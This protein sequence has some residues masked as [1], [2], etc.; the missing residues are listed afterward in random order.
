MQT[1]I[2][3]KRCQSFL[4]NAYYA[5]LAEVQLDLRN[6]PEQSPISKSVRLSVSR[7]MWLIPHQQTARYVIDQF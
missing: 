5:H 4:N 2:V 6:Q 1:T 7:K 3:L